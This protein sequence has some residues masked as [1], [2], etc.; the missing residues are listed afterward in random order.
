MHLEWYLL[1]WIIFE[2]IGNKVTFLFCGSDEELRKSVKR[3]TTLPI[4]LNSANCHLP[5]GQGYNTTNAYV[6]FIQT[7]A[8]E[9]LYKLT[10]KLY[11]FKLP[12]YIMILSLKN[13][14]QM[15]I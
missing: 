2:K 10:V 11:D 13:C 7:L 5:C 3:E 9:N 4:V 6:I 12:V 1:F 15:K 14:L 8:F